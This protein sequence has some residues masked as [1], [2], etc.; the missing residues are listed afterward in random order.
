MRGCTYASIFNLTPQPPGWRA[1]VRFYTLSSKA[2]VFSEE[3][4][5]WRG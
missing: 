2:S 3:M 4:N 1:A 5:R